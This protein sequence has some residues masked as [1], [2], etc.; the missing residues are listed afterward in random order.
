MKI[1]FLYVS[2]AI[3]AGLLTTNI[4]NSLIDASSWGS[5]MPVSIQTAREYFKTVNPGNFFRIISP[6]NQ[7]FALI[8]LVLF[9]KASPAI[10][11]MLGIAF[12]LYVLS[13]V[14][15]LAYF[16]PRNEIMFKSPLSNVG[17]LRKAFA[18]WNAMN[19]V[20]SSICFVG[21]VF[22]FLSLHKITIAA[23]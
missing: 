3:A 21:L 17:N 16:Y 19:W 20:R 23:N 13:D 11:L 9:W 1:I 7:L 8:V 18:E 15:T 10:R 6:A 4:Y 14:M 5:N 12:L 2:I 22:S